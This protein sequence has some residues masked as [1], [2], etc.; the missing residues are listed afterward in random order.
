MFSLFAVFL[1]LNPEL[2]LDLDLNPDLDLELDWSMIAILI[3]ILISILVLVG[4]R[5]TNDER[6]LRA[7]PGR[8]SVVSPPVRAALH[9]AGPDPPDQGGQDDGA[10]ADVPAGGG[11]GALLQPPAP[12]GDAGE[13]DNSQHQRGRHSPVHQAVAARHGLLPGVSGPPG[14]GIPAGPFT[15]A[16]WALM[17]PSQS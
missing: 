7:S 10:A 16:E 13:D 11:G 12:D 4:Q 8:L 6:N 14:T 2:I 17:L 1:D 5:A 9:R 3:P 15:K